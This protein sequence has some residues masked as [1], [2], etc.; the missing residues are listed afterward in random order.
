YSQIDI[1]K[2][3]IHGLEGLPEDIDTHCRQYEAIIK[4]VGGID[5]QML[6][7]GSNGHIGFNEPSSSLASRTRAKTLTKETIEANRHFFKGGEEV[8]RYCLTMGI[9]TILEAKTIL[10]LAFGKNKEDAVVN[11][12]E[13]PVTAAVPAS[14]LQLHP[15]VKIILDED[16]ASRLTKKE[17]YCW[18]YNNKK[19][20]TQIRSGNK[21]PV[22]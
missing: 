21:P 4:S 22:L 17:Y 5:I 6:G 1:K 20:I 14:A 16:A 11:C 2:E 10:L 8:P 13:G 9:G 12:V 3:N 19:G 7:I 15:H 18:V